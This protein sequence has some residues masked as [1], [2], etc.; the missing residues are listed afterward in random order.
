MDMEESRKDLQA[1][2]DNAPPLL[3]FY[4]ISADSGNKRATQ[5]SLDEN[6]EPG[7]VEL[8]R[9]KKK[10]KINPMGLAIF[11]PISG[12]EPNNFIGQIFS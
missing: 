11:T 9:E 3:I 7:R 6:K 1:R 8:W 4:R 10:K 2:P 12:N 5:E